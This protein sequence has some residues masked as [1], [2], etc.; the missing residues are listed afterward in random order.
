MG[1]RLTQ[2]FANKISWTP[3]TSL[4]RSTQLSTRRSTM[5][6]S[7]FVSSLPVQIMIVPTPTRPTDCQIQALKTQLANE[8]QARA[9]TEASMQA[10]LKGLRD[11]LTKEKQA[12]EVTQ[13]AAKHWESLR[14]KDLETLKVKLAE[15]KKDYD[16]KL[17]EAK[18]RLDKKLVEINKESD[19]K[20]KTAQANRNPERTALKANVVEAEHKA[21]EAKISL[22]TLA[23]DNHNLESSLNVLGEL[24]SESQQHV[25]E[26]HRRYQEAH[27][28]YQE[29]QAE[30]RNYQKLLE[31][32]LA[33]RNEALEQL[34]ASNAGF[35][36]NRDV[37]SPHFEEVL[38]DPIWERIAKDGIRFISRCLGLFL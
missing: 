18:N 38:T 37:Q 28:A 20:L 26:L 7:A 11:E 5:S 17:A 6:F 23:S 10:Q 19:T 32:A 1:D 36:A 9:M 2:L 21:L 12:H 4:R 15:A 14:A 34:E 27:D 30:I 35:Y 8:Q 13:K 31:E 24:E 25:V 33:V 22:D 3:L 29:A 16:S